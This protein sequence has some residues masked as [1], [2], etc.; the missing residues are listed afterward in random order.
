MDIAQSFYR[1]KISII[2]I[3]FKNFKKHQNKKNV[4]F[5]SRNFTNVNFFFKISSVIRGLRRQGAKAAQRSVAQPAVRQILLC[6]N[7]HR[8]FFHIQD[9]CERSWHNAHIVEVTSDS[10]VAKPG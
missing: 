7:Q 5:F 4:I 8:G 9:F 10:I 3:F 1:V 6:K 2:F